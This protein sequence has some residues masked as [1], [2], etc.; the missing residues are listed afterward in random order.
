MLSM[1]D[2]ES[3]VSSDVCSAFVVGL[4]LKC[5]LSFMVFHFLAFQL[6]I[7]FECLLPYLFFN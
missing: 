2:E 1:A 5:T 4:K 7:G 3:G 6:N